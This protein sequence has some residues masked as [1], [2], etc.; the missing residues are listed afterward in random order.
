MVRGQPVEGKKVSFVK[1]FIIYCRGQSQLFA[2]DGQFAVSRLSFCL[3]RTGDST[4]TAEMERLLLCCLPD[5][6]ILHLVNLF[7]VPSLGIY[8]KKW[9]SVFRKMIPCLYMLS[10]ESGE[11]FYN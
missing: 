8:T 10:I 3:P 6:L 4:R 5:I 11:S 1:I 7:L 2:R 9:G